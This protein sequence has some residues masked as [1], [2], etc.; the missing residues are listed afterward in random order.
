[1]LEHFDLRSV[2]KKQIKLS[3][4]SQFQRA[5]ELAIKSGTHLDTVLGYRQRY[6]ELL[7]RKEIDPKFLKHLSQVEIDWPHIFEKIHEDEQ[8]DQHHQWGNAG[9]GLSIPN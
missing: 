8:K 2:P 3:I 9:G 7:G 5:L 6:L 1:M 4:N